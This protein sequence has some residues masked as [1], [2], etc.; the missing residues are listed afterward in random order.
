MSKH[1]PK[2]LAN[3]IVLVISL[4]LVSGGGTAPGQQASASLAKPAPTPVP[5]AKV[6]LEAQSALASLQEI[7]ASVS[8]A[9]SSADGIARTLLDLTNEIDARI[10][11]DTRLLTTS[12]SIDLR[13][14]LKLTW[15]NFGDSL[16]V[17]ARELTQH[18]TSLEEQLARLDQLT[19]TWQATL[20]S[21]KQPD[22]PTPV[23]QSVQSVVDTVERTRQAAESVLV[24]VLTLQSRLSEEEA[25]VRTVLS[26]I[27]QLENRSFQF[28]FVRD[29]PPIWSLE[30]SLGTEWKK[31][32]GEAFSSQ[33]KAS[34]AFTKRLPS[35]FLIHALFIVMIATALQWMRRRSRKLVEE[36]P[37][38][39][40]RAL[41]ILDLPVSTAFALSML[42]IPLNLCASTAL[43]N[44]NH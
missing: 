37:D 42:L 9:R 19:K 17:S 13:Y 2:K 28:F 6:A 30:T 15:Q 25:R 40:Q 3:R 39:Q 35:T 8:R 12:L 5:L 16:L 32:S 26:S 10:A 43:D 41:P 27:E 22:T 20:Q 34:T 31:Q 21:A 23:L 38:L 11:G 18:S 4:V 36:K 29:S 1:F 44:C 33:L 24:H 14:W 7:D